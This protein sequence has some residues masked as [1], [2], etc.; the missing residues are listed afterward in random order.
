LKNLRISKFF[1]VSSGSQLRATTNL[2]VTFLK[3]VKAPNMFH[4]V[5]HLK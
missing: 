4:F 2:L 5:T 1:N 3:F